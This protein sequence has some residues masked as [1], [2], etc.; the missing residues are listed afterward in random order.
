MHFSSLSCE[1]LVLNWDEGRPFE[2]ESSSWIKFE[3]QDP[4]HLLSIPC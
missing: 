3:N 4:T 1:I 2:L